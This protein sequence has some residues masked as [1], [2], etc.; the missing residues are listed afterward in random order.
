M[1]DTSSAK[2]QR[3]QDKLQVEKY[4]AWYGARSEEILNASGI[5]T[6]SISKGMETLPC[7]IEGLQTSCFPDVIY[8]ALLILLSE[9][10][11]ID[12]TG[13]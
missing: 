7:S 12:K 6:C 11:M 3:K 1:W 5:V 13:S 4:E 10:H 8:V 2:H 9:N